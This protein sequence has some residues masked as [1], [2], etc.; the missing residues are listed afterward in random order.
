MVI[1]LVVWLIVFPLILG[2]VNGW[3]L[4]GVDAGVI[5]GERFDRIVAVGSHTGAEE[6]W[7]SVTAT[8][9]AS[10]A[11]SLTGTTAYILSEGADESCTV[12]DISVAT[13]GTAVAASTVSAFTPLGST[14]TA[15]IPAV[16]VPASG[17]PNTAAITVSGC[18]FTSAG[19][20]F[21]AGGL[22]GL[23][24]IILQAA[25]LAAPIALLFALGSFGTS[26]LKN[27]GNH[28]IMSAVLTVIC[29]L[30]VATLL[31]TFIPFLSGAFEA[32]DPNRFVMYDQGLGNVASVI[33]NFFGVVVV[34]SIMM[35]AWQLVQQ[36]R[37]RNTISGGGGQRM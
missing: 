23:I 12:S 18:K 30:L 36:L 4:Q 35:V 31:N 11:T 6:A 7:K 22:S 34:S 14:V 21:N 3:Y 15:S 1:G 33:G 17:D 27:M 10:T 24:E 16:A 5:S 20:V 32:I 37:G 28:P 2:A 9:S 8:E 29:F 26:F 19:G 13:G 25:G